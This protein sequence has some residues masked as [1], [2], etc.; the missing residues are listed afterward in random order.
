MSLKIVPI[1]SKIIGVKPNNKLRLQGSKYI[2]FTSVI[3]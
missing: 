1:S 2:E 3:S